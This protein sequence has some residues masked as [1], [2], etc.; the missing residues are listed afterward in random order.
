MIIERLKKHYQLFV[1]LI[2]FITAG[3]S[4]LIYDNQDAFSDNNIY[5]SISALCAIVAIVVISG[6]WNYLTNGAQIPFLPQIIRCNYQL[7]YFALSL[8]FAY[9]VFENYSPYM[10][11]DSAFTLRYLD[12]FWEGFFIVLLLEVYNK[13]IACDCFKINFGNNS[14]CICQ[15]QICCFFRNKSDT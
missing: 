5:A 12:N 15:L 6:S 9:I 7:V 10:F 2:L 8:L 13:S 4:Y 14:I 1:P 3:V 11:D